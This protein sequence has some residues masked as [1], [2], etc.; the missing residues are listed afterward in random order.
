MKTYLATRIDF[1]D[2]YNSWC[3][4][5]SMVGKVVYEVCCAIMA[6]FHDRVLETSANGEEGNAVAQCFGE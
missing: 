2:M 3:V 1:Q 5:C 4:G 6:G